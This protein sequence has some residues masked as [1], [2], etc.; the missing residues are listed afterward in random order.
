[1]KCSVTA[2]LIHTLNNTNNAVAHEAMSSASFPQLDKCYLNSTKEPG[3]HD[4][5]SSA[6]RYPLPLLR[7]LQE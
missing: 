6:S 3:A 7:V 5:L 2:R 1:M 4:V